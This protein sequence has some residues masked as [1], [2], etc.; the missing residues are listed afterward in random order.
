MAKII[1]EFDSADKTVKV[2]KDGKE[3]SNVKSI[4]VYPN[5]M[6]E[7]EMCCNVMSI[8]EDEDNDLKEMHNLIA[9]T[10]FDASEYLTKIIR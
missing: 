4:S 8:D 1:I 3:I 9:K 6:N 10:V 7:Q 2:T 5:Y